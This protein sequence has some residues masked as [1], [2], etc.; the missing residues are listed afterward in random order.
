MMKLKVQYF[1]M[2]ADIAGISAEDWV[3]EDAIT[4]GGLRAE[5]QKKYAEMK[6]SKVKV[7]VNKQIS[8]DHLVIL[9]DSAVALLPPFAGG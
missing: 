9:P 1:G 2:L 6:I 8:E 3:V 5:I 4:V 7:A